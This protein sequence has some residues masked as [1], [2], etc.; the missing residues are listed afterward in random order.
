MII[1]DAK[2]MRFYHGRRMKSRDKSELPAMVYFFRTRCHFFAATIII[3][4]RGHT[5]KYLIKIRH[6]SG[7]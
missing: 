3:L 4:Q 1:T 5:G 2:V 6:L 7:T